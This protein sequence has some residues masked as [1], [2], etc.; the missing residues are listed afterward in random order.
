MILT[1][2]RLGHH[3]D[4]IA[5]HP[6]GGGGPI[7][8]A[9]TLP[10]ELVEGTQD[11][12][13]LLN[14]KIITPS[15]DRVKPPCRHARACGGC[16]LQHASDDFVA[17]WKQEVVETALAAQGLTAPFLAIQTSPARTPR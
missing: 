11:G 15:A 2:D 1:V 9:G 14:P 10:G 6:D 17:R 16:Q 13:R 3:G 7:F 8:V 5:A 4:G 12:D